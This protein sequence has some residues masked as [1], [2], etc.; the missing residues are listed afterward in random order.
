LKSF[1]N[2][3]QN[4]T[5]LLQNANEVTFFAPSNDAIANYNEQNENLT[6]DGM[7]ALIE[8]SLL[9]GGYPTLSFTN[10]S[11]FVASH[12]TNPQY[13]NVTGGQRV[14][15]VLG[16]NGMPEVVTGNKSISPSSTTVAIYLLIS[17]RY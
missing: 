16:S 3:S 15:L 7:Q 11:Q 14:E 9:Q 8:F 17:K 5:S 13:A 4:I 1:F 12:L 6:T 2:A 10:D